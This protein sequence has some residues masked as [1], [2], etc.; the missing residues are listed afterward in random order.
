M[1][2]PLRGTFCNLHIQA[3]YSWAGWALCTSGVQL[4]AMGLQL[5][6]QLLPLSASLAFCSKRL[7]MLWQGGQ[8]HS[9][10]CAGANCKNLRAAQSLP[11]CDG[12][13][14]QAKCALVFHSMASAKRKGRT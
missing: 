13:P 1:A 10:T 12:L 2:G 8:Q 11:P 3:H 9:Q 4:A 6:L 14:A 7:Q 5:L